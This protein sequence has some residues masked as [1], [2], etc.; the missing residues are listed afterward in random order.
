MT[1]HAGEAPMSART[2]LALL[3]SLYFSQGLPF[4]FFTQVLPVLLR[5]EGFSLT[6]IGFLSSLIAVPLRGEVPRADS[7][8]L[9]LGRPA[10]RRRRVLSARH[11]VNWSE[12]PVWQEGG[13]PLHVR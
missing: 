10:R 13:G 11:P 1:G 8:V 9:F 3:A 12:A 5:K 2:K 6:D 7:V 4:G